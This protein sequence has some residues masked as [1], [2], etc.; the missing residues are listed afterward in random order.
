MP[1]KTYTV[2]FKQK[3]GLSAC[4]FYPSYLVLLHTSLLKKPS[5]PLDHPSKSQQLL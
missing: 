1:Q 4:F 3:A 2:Y 5:G